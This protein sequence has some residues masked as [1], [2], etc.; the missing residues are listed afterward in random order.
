MNMNEPASQKP[1]RLWPGVAAA[2]LLVLVGYVI[3]IFVPSFAGLGMIG[4][5]VCALLVILWWLLFSRARWYERLGAIVLMI[6]A[7]LA[8][9]YVVHPSI[10]G[11]GMGNLAQVLAIPTLSVALVAWA[12][13]SRRLA[14][15]ARGA[16]AVVAVVLGCLP[17]TVVRTG[18]ITGDGKSDFH[19]R[20]TKTPEEQFSR[21]LPRSR[22][23][24]RQRRLRSRLRRRQ[25]NRRNRCPQKPM[26]L[27]KQNRP[28]P[29]HQRGARSGPA[30]ADPGGTA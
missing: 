12:F 19:F 10:A 21:R 4:A 30:F 5:V 22:R 13:A 29:Q 9:E 23:R 14:R 16:A 28:L 25:R 7:A 24:P 11:G 6:A 17:W 1:L 26:R 2:V 15:G 3:P 18:G 20:W 27:P 8:V